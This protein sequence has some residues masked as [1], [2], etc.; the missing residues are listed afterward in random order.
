MIE[1]YHVCITLSDFF[2]AKYYIFIPNFNG[3][4]EYDERKNTFEQLYQA[5]IVRTIKVGVIVVASTPMTQISIA[6][7]KL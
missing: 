7:P 5:Y 1:H 2:S 3:L 6:Y 4:F